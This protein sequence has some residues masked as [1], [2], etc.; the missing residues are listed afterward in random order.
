MPDWSAIRK[1]VLG[2]EPKSVLPPR[3]RLPVF[4]KA[5]IEFTRKS[6]EE[7]ASTTVLGKIVETDSGLTCELLRHVNS[8]AFGLRRKI[9]SAKHAISALGIRETC[10]F[11]LSSSLAGAIRGRQSKVIDIREFSANNLERAYFAQEVAKLLKADPDLAFSAAMLADFILPDV[12]NQLYPSYHG[13]VE[14]DGDEPQRLVQYEQATLGWQ[15]PQAGALVMFKWG[16]PDDLVC[17]V[18]LHHQGFKLLA[19]TKLRSTSAAAVAVAAFL[20]DGF[21]QVP[22][23]MELL[24][25]LE[26]K[27]SA[28][29]LIEIAER[30]HEQVE[31]VGLGLAEHCSLLRNCRAVGAT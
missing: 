23:G 30:V 24:L 11:L 6:Q 10:L 15:H 28:F 3:V 19:D 7:D 18:M 2:D 27:W 14:Q 21:R 22:D 17:C 13:F 12:T 8:S 20:P 25:R 5:A 4:P 31:C 9:S 29:R 16:F 1:S 26:R